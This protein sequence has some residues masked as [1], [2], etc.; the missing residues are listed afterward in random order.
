[1]NTGALSL[2]ESSN[3]FK[4]MCCK[5]VYKNPGNLMNSLCLHSALWCAVLLGK[6]PHC[7]AEAVGFRC[8]DNNRSQELFPWMRGPASMWHYITTQQP[9]T[10]KRRSA[11]LK[12]VCYAFPIAGP[13]ALQS[14]CNLETSVYDRGNRFKNSRPLELDSNASSCMTKSTG[15]A[16]L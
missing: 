15:T 6:K 13:L 10:T 16:G 3:H 11:S 7:L 14:I 4:S 2:N 5:A 9:A 1:M 8:S 12:S